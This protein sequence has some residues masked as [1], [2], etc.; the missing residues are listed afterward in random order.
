[1]AGSVQKDL[2]NDPEKKAAA[3]F[4][5]AA[6]PDLHWHHQGEEDPGNCRDKEGFVLCCPECDC[7][8]PEYPAEGTAAESASGVSGNCF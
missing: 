6:E 3:L 1:M 7:H 2:G 8:E 4:D 5:A